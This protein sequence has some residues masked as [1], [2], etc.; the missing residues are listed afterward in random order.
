[1]SDHEASNVCVIK[2]PDVFQAE[3]A[4]SQEEEGSS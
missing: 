1:M 4:K 3:Q 2:L